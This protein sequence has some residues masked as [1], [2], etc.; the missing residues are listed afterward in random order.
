MNR[1]GA[2]GFV[3]S[4]RRNLRGGRFTVVLVLQLK[5]EERGIS[6]LFP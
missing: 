5:S 3:L 2:L 6:S 1:P 4:P